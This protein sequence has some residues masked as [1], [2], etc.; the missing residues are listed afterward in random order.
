MS[1]VGK[2]TKAIGILRVAAWRVL[3]PERRHRRGW[4]TDILS[5]VE[6]VQG[7]GD[8]K[9]IRD[10]A[11]AT[12]EHALAVDACVRCPRWR[13]QALHEHALA[14]LAALMDP[15]V[16]VDAQQAPATPSHT[17]GQT[18]QGALRRASR[19]AT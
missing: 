14:L 4:L 17:A 1:R 12:R 15:D 10:H 16:E 8:Y 6:L 9:P 2:M 18:S 3:V 19:H 7:M 13:I 5:A 11:S